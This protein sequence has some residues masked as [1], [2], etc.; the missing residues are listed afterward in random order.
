MRAV[1]ALVSLILT[2]CAPPDAQRLLAWQ[3]DG[4]GYVVAPRDMAVE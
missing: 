2:S 4:D 3:V 1:L